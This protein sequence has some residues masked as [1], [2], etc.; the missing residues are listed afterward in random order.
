MEKLVF[1]DIDRFVCNWVRKLFPESVVLNCDIS[2]L[3]P[4][5]FIKA[6]NRV[7][8]FSGIAG[9]EYA[10]ELAGWPGGRPVWTGSCPCQPF[11]G[12]GKR[13]GIEDE[14]HLWPAMFRLI[15]ECRPA[16]VFG[17]QVA[18]KDGREWLSR[19]RVDM[20]TLGYAVGAADLCSPGTGEKAEGWIV[21]GDKGRWEPIVIGAP[22]IRQRLYWVANAIGQRIRG[23]EF[24]ELATKARGVQ[25][26]EWK[27]ERIR[28]DSQSMC[29]SEPCRLADLSSN[30]RRQSNTDIGGLNQGI[31]KEGNGGRPADSCG[32]I[33][34]RMGNPIRSGREGCRSGTGSRSGPCSD[35]GSIAPPG[36]WSDFDVVRCRDGKS[37]RIESGVFPLAHGVPQRMGRLRGYGNAIVPPLAA[38]F[39]RSFLEAEA[40]M[41]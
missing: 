34:E 20:E 23:S 19:V 21:C 24:R 22:H 13:L 5:G 39:I 25:G 7:H 16:T 8:F 33:I 1:N 27:R 26:A 40:E 38:T 35:G 29:Y 37:R 18:S 30:G 28:I 14:R 11:S 3:Q 17:E 10:L 31:R 15:R 6:S 12:A 9:W 32:S 4:G 41:T 2:R 36:P